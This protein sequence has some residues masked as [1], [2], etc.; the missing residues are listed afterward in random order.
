M[1]NRNIM[2]D[3]IE[4]KDIATFSEN[5]VIDNLKRINIIYGANGTGKSSISRVLYNITEHPSCKISWHDATPL[6]VLVY[7]KEFRDNNYVEH[8][9]GIFTLGESTKETIDE[10]AIKQEELQ[11]KKCNLNNYRASL[12][13]KKNEREERFSDFKNS[14]WDQVLKIHETYFPKTF[15]KAGTKDIFLK[16]LLDAYK[17]I[18]KSASLN[19]LKDKA[20]LLFGEQPLQMNRLQEFHD[21]SCK[22]IETADI[23][24]KIIV[25]A[26]DVDIARLIKTLGNAD[27]VNHGLKYI[28]E[29]DVC[30]FCQQPTINADFRNKV[31]LF[32]NDEYKHNIQQVKESENAYREN[33]NYMLDVIA[34]VIMTEKD[35]PKSL[36]D[37]ERM[38]SEYAT[39][40]NIVETNIERIKTKLAEPS[41][42]ISLLRTEEIVDKLNAYINIANQKIEKQNNLVANFKKEKEALINAIWNYFADFYKEKI[43]SLYNDLE[44]INK[45]EDSFNKKY[46]LTRSECLQLE[47]EILTLEKNVTSIKPTINEINK[48][49]KSFGFTNFSIC[50][51]KN[52]P[53]YYQIVRE[54]GELAN[55][56][57]SE[58][59][60]TFI[61]FLYYLQ[62]VKGSTSST[63]INQDRVLVVDDPVSSLDSNVL[64]VVSTMLRAIFDETLTESRIKQVF[65]LTHNVYFHKEVS[66]VD[67]HCKWRDSVSH[68][69]LRK[70]NNQSSITHY[71]KN[72]PIKSSYDLL[73]AEY[74]NAPQTSY[75]IIQNIMRRIIENYFQVFG[76]Y[77]PDAILEKFEDPEERKICKSLISWINDGSHSIA[78]DL[79]VEISDEQIIKYKDVFEKIF[80]YMGHDAH[81]KMMTRMPDKEDASPH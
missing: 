29:T 47:D 16:N 69:V 68:Y 28:H 9:P 36:L 66:F 5:V 6:Q 79:Y 46:A 75:A 41:R 78:D 77:T 63:G 23:W 20:S 50:E 24:S 4:I 61:T 59:E 17:S 35:R 3:K 67:K 80:K 32:F 72:T 76:G 33:S 12:E 49:L 2:I 1:S 37:I 8:I 38:D 25:G 27:W 55:D 40:K 39:L 34:N 15:I 18:S 43:V 19:E 74:M 44:S 30:P 31:S 62:L 7:N 65:L 51:A 70:N 73:W 52:N 54:N 14:A 71:G 21:D 56:T 53:N 10:L 11:K 45:A 64:F 42:V 60:S 13:K 81:Y 22:T 58:G 48:Q 26:D 57:L